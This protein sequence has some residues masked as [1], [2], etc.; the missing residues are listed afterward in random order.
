MKWG[1]LGAI[2]ILLLLSACASYKPA[3]LDIAGMQRARVQRDIDSPDMRDLLQ[4]NGL[5]RQ[6][7]AW[8]PASFSHVQLFVIA[9]AT[10]PDIAETRA[11]LRQALE[12]VRTARALPN[13]TVGLAFERDTQA[14]AESQPWLWGIST[15]FA[16]DGGIRRRLDM[17]LADANVRAARLTLTEA[18]WKLRDGLRHAEVDL[19]VADAQCRLAQPALATASALDDAY[20]LRISAGE[21]ASTDRLP[22]SQALNQARVALATC[23]GA[24]IDARARL[25][26]LLDVSVGTAKTIH[27]AWPGFDA[28]ENVDATQID[29]LSE[30]ALLT[31]PDLDAALAAYDMREVELAQ[32]VHAQYPQ[33]SIGPGYTYDHGIRKLTL[34]LSAALPVLNQNQGP[35]AEALAQ[36]E[37][38][39]RHAEAV[40]ADVD[41]DIALS[42]A[43]LDNSRRGWLLAEQGHALTTRDLARATQ[44]LRLGAVDRTAVLNATVADNAA[45]QTELAALAQWHRNQTALE[46]ALRAPLDAD[47][48]RLPAL[49]EGHS[50]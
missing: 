2:G 34:G 30:Q 47:E 45:A 46:N 24:G 20:A 3:P 9:L 44:A 6:G 14:N 16:L 39:G 37:A 22:A 38:A 13:P 12:G 42:R 1:H 50:P 32:Q 15:T 18:V 7:D 4:K 8:P 41:N 27:L 25:A 35:I 43:E 49:L 48:A 23:S 36:R 5:W 17:K 28:P 26:R 11:Q 21:A 10:N 31:R 19:L 29:H 40:Q 33:L